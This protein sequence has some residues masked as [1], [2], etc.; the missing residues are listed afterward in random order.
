M[1]KIEHSE[2][3]RMD[4]IGWSMSE[5]SLKIDFID[6]FQLQLKKMKQKARD[7]RLYTMKEL[8]FCRLAF[9]MGNPSLISGP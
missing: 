6:I 4:N 9:N 8:C 2:F 5:F 3:L 7:L 1:H